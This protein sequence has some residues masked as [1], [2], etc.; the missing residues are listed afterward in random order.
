MSSRSYFTRCAENV[1]SF[2]VRHDFFKNSFFPPTAIEW[3]KIDKNIRKS[4]SLNISKNRVYNCHNPKGIKLLIRLRVGLSHLPEHKF[5][6]SFQ[7]TPNPICNCG[8]DIEPTSHYLLHCPDYLE[9]RKTL[10]NTISCIVPNIFNFNNDQLTEIL[11][12]GKEDLDNIN[13]TSILDATINYLI[14]TKRF[15]AQLFLCSLDVMVLTLMLHLKFIF[16]FF[17]FVLF[18]LFLSFYYFLGD[19]FYILYALF[20]PRYITT[21]ICIPGDCKFFWFN[22]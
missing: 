16:L 22:V 10:L 3:N 18:L 21:Y 5:K 1:P 12:Y 8:K 6:Y 11:L 17:F 2:N 13:N 20:V 14:E 15:N 7:D 19:F 9:E 4:K